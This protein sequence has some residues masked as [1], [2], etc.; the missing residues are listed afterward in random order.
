MLMKMRGEWDGPCADDRWRLVSR[1]Q[2]D[3]SQYVGSAADDVAD[4][5]QERTKSAPA[6]LRCAVQQAR[7]A[8]GREGEVIIPLKEGLQLTRGESG[9]K[10]AEVSISV[11]ARIDRLRLCQVAP[12]CDQS[13][14]RSLRSPF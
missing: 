6:Q 11:R 8:I 1:R 3:Q 14:Q 10:C 9:Q 12:A 13:V 4:R 2:R 7:R 5:R